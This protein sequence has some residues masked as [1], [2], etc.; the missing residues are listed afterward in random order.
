MLTVSEMLAFLFEYVVVLTVVVLQ[1]WMKLWQ[2][3]SKMG[4][5]AGAQ[6]D[7][8]RARSLKSTRKTKP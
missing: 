3:R 8:Y 4:R 1:R 2:K 5:V 7:S 6:M